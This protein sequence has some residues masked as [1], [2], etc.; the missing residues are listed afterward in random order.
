MAIY[1]RTYRVYWSET[2]AA[3]MMHFSN[4][5][6]V[7]ERTEEEFLASLGITQRGSPGSRLLMPRVHA[8]CDYK[9]PL[10]PGDDYRVDIVDVVLGKSSITYVYEIYNLTSGQLAATCKIV[11][12]SYDERGD[13]AVEIPKEVREALMR[14]GARERNSAN[15]SA[16]NDD[17]A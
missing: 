5:F 6:R 4:F 10:R 14:A 7:C 2:D 1:S 12:V 13:R 3:L 9:R 8:E 15:A 11:T 17:R 16:R